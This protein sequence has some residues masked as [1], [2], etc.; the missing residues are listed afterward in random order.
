MSGRFL[1]FL[2]RGV[3]APVVISAHS[4]AVRVASGM[5]F[6]R[7][8][9]LSSVSVFMSRQWCNLT[10]LAKLKSVTRYELTDTISSCPGKP[11]GSDPM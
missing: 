10:N 1:L 8:A 6:G 9:L 4:L 11:R 7:D 5:L 3:H 2:G